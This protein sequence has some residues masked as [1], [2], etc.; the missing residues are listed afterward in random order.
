MALN[1]LLTEMDGFTID[2]KRPV[3]VLAATNF[4]IEEGKG[5]MGT[6]DAALARRFDR[7]ILVDLPNKQDRK[8][9]LVMMLGKH[10]SHSVSDTMIERLAGRS[11]GMSLANLASIIELAARTAIKKNEALSDSILEEA[12]EVS[13]HGEKKDWGHEYLERVARHEAGH[14]FM[15]H[16]S[17]STPS[18]LTIVARGSH[19]GYMEHADDESSPLKTK[20]ELFARIR[21]SLGGR[22][23]ELVYYGENDGVSSG[24]SGD[25]QSA[26]RIA[27]TMICSYGMDETIG[28]A[29]LSPEEAANG[30]LAAKITQ[31][32]NEIL[33]K[34]HWFIYNILEV[35]TNFE[36]VS[37]FTPG[38]LMEGFFAIL[39]IRGAN[40]LA[41]SSSFF[42]SALWAA[43]S[44]RAY[45]AGHLRE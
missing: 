45:F 33:A 2:A 42:A 21:T 19:G 37:C 14:A 20:D 26:T 44:E 3:F 4:D 32:V 38:G 25:L 35:Y 27:R 15:C 18:Y 6:I 30:P 16:L 40:R 23:A 17:G 5:G 29:A 11:T 36:S 22:A 24:A 13:K 31:R 12:F 9:Y 34:E 39:D 8:R 41:C 1:A 10:K 43:F 28:L 7:K